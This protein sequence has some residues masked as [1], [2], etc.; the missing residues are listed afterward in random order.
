MSRGVTVK[1]LSRAALATLEQRAA[2][3]RQH[4]YAPYSEFRVGAAVR[5]GGRTFVAA[6]VEN[7]S[8]GLTVCAERNAVAAA[9]AAGATRLEAIAIASDASPPSAPCGACRQVLMEFAANP[10]NIA[11]IAMNPAG[12]RRE[13]TLAELLP[14]D[15]SA[16]DLS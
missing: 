3:V 4:A 14:A 5:M 7:A 8:Y 9:V 11:V 16:E 6:N 2:K 15:F 1:R 10:A 12:E 13:F